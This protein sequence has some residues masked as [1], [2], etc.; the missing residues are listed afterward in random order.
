ME[1]LLEQEATPAT[2]SP[3]PQGLS[4]M[5][6]VGTVLL[7]LDRQVG[8]VD[9]T[10]ISCQ[11][12]TTIGKLNSSISDLVPNH[13]KFHAEGKCS[14]DGHGAVCAKYGTE[15]IRLR[16]L[17]G[18]LESLDGLISERANVPIRR[19]IIEL[20]RI[21]VENKQT[22][23][24]DFGPLKPGDRVLGRLTDAKAH[25]VAHLCSISRYGNQSTT[26]VNKGGSNE[27]QSLKMFTNILSSLFWLLVYEAIPGD[28][29]FDRL[30]LRGN[31]LIVTAPPEDPSGEK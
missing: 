22:S 28:I 24:R 5:E 25:A 11:I 26:V 18:F 3:E 12:T 2:I 14:M 23:L 6:T 19:F 27:K 20:Q 7:P 15:L 17:I 9:F 30:T 16:L 31:W 4:V 21:S 8:D 1:V 10:Y 29:C 13:K